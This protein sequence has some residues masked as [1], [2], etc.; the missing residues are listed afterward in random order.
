MRAA[1]L[2]DRLVLLMVNEA[3]WCLQEGV[4]ASPRDADAGAVLGL[5]FPPFRGGPFRWVDAVGAAEVVARMER[6]RTLCG[7]R[8]TP[9]PLLL[10]AARTGRPFHG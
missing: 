6:L 7:K 2:V 8:F 10:E 1:D 5:G 4:V 3:A 9:A